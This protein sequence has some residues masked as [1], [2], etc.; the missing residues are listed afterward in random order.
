MQATMHA[1]LI[2]G[3]TKE[4]RQEHIINTLKDWGVATFDTLR[5]APLET[6]IGIQAIRQMQAQV[7]LAPLVSPVTVVV[8]E[9]AQ[10]LTVEAQ[11]ALLK[12]LEEPPPQARLILE[13][14]HQSVLLPT[15]LSRCQIIDLGTAMQ[16]S[17]DEIFSCI[18]ILKKLSEAPIGKRLQLLETIAANRENT[19]TW[20]DLA[21][22][23][24]REE[25]KGKFQ[26][27]GYRI[28]LEKPGQLLR[29]LLT[30]QSQLGLNISPKLVL[31]HVF[32]SAI[33]RPK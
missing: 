5:I 32:L 14:S 28:Q 17:A 6:S 33:N 29:R 2:S 15:V 1:F 19:Q 22:A 4:K 30:A 7:A 13:T 25:M 12:T 23:A 11:Q 16:Y 9:D 27:K 10:L 8:I 26:G 21:I 20:V 3:G 24:A 18:N 31:D